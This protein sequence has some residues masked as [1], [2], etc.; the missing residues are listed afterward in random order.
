MAPWVPCLWLWSQNALGVP[1]HNSTVKVQ[2][3]WLP[4]G[5]IQGPQGDVCRVWRHARSWVL[6][7]V[8]IFDQIQNSRKGNRQLAW[9]IYS[10]HNMVFISLEDTNGMGK[11]W[12]NGRVGKRL[13]PVLSC[14]PSAIP[15][16]RGTDWFTPGA[17][18]PF[19]NI[20][21][22]CTWVLHSTPASMCQLV[23]SFIQERDMTCLLCARL[24]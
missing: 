4:C 5:C 7:L 17:I 9:N 6:F 16:F 18:L 22:C 11:A 2:V 1:V 10:L 24:C 20:R 3:T 13:L 14:S 12:R 8:L 15:G 21:D 19:I 23:L